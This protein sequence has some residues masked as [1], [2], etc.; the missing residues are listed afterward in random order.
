MTFRARDCCLSLLLTLMLSA[1][2]N[3]AA[4]PA[5]GAA[6][7]MENSHIEGV[8]WNHLGSWSVDYQR[9]AGTGSAIIDTIDDAINQPAGAMVAATDHSATDNHPWTFHVTGQL[10][11][12]SVALSTLFVGE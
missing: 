12:E 1:W 2:P 5:I 3:A 7:A 8:N 4:D 9:L 11:V 10:S 6:F